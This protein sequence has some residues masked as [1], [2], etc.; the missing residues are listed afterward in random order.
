MKKSNII[1]TVFAAALAVAWLAMST[2]NVVRARRMHG[3]ALELMR[4]METARVRVVATTDVEAVK[5]RLG[6]TA[7][8]AGTKERVRYFGELTPEEIRISGDTM[9]LFSPGR[10]GDDVLF[11]GEQ[12]VGI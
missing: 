6:D 10:L 1:L 5:S 2:C 4:Q 12:V 3:Y 11:F 8:Y 9:Y 7:Y